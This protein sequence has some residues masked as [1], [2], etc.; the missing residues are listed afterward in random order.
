[1]SVYQATVDPAERNTSHTMMLELVGHDK[2]VLDVGCA[3]GYL[4]EALG[5]N[6]CRVSGIEYDPV[7]AEKARPSLVE[8]VVADLNTD[9]LA[10]QFPD[11]LYDSIVFGDV[12]EHLL[13][14]D[15]V[16]ASSLSLLRPGASVVISIPNVAHGAVRLS[17]LQ[18][19][20]NYSDTGLLDRTHIRFFTF[21]TLLAMLERAGLSVT[22][23]RST[24]AD[25][26][27]T[28]I[29]VEDSVLPPD[30]VTWVRNQAHAHAYQFVLTAQRAEG[31]VDHVQH[32]LPAV[33]PPQ[34]HDV[35]AEVSELKGE[36]AGL[37]GEIDQLNEEIGA[38]QT[39]IVGLRQEATHEQ[40]IN[41]ALRRT[42]LTSRDH[43]IGHEAQVGR[44]RAELATVRHHLHTTTL[45]AQY[46]HSELAKSIKD[47]QDAH[48]RL[49][50][51][52]WYRHPLRHGVRGT[53][54]VVRR[55]V[56]PRVWAVITA[57]I[58]PMVNRRRAER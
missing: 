38:L 48:A 43:A 7:E 51:A 37:R 54:V 11:R 29:A 58:R 47:S 3:S 52:M 4:A 41:T 50:T 36:A 19:H 12:L 31:G 16:L 6:G 1:M 13:D 26:L 20:W 49:A 2:D 17:L 10:D 46:A 34:V 27:G 40:D 9:D 22:E 14:P 24:V 5:R 55:A 8:L 30:A 45:D 53:A 28:E 25:P 42:V 18:G 35:H 33:P 32:V 21:D 56:G 57:P 23:L 44:L 39:R 15:A